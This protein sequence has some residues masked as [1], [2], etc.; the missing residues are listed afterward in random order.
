M[1]GLRLITN[2]REPGEQDDLVG[3][4][5]Q[6]LSGSG[7]DPDNHGE[8]ADHHLNPDAGDDGGQPLHLGGGDPGLGDV[9]I[10]SG[11]EIEKHEAHAVNFSAVVLAG[12][13]VGGLM[14]K[15]ESEEQQPELGKIAATLLCVKL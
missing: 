7:V 10:K 11:R 13:A 4:V 5:V 6:P 2:H 9:D 8:A 12:E 1:S 14:D 3:E 15:A